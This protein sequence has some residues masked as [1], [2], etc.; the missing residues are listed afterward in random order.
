[1]LLNSVLSTGAAGAYLARIISAWFGND[2]ASAVVWNDSHR[3]YVF[4]FVIVIKHF[5]MI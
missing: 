4:S 2:I 1:M 3:I 5:I